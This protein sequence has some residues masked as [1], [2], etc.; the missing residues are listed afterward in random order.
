MTDAPRWRPIAEAPESGPMLGWTG[1]R[2]VVGR[3]YPIGDRI[4]LIDT[5]TARWAICTHWMPL[6]APPEGSDG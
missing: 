5:R 3:R 6:P 2:W 4:A 1:E